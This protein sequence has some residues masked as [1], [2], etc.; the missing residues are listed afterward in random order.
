MSY[1]NQ[2][3][4]SG[5]PSH[6]PYPP[7]QGGYPPPQQPYGNQGYNRPPPGPPPGQ[8]MNQGYGPPMGG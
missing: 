8:P 5:Y 6:S 7:Q 4:P 3:P 1:Y 2:G